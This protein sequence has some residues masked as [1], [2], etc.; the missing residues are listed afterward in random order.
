MVTFTK[1]FL[2]LLG[3]S[4]QAEWF[5]KFRDNPLRAQRK[6]IKQYPFRLKRYI[7][8]KKINLQI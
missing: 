4:Y 3:S 7:W 2:I 8:P 6:M 5:L 1:Y